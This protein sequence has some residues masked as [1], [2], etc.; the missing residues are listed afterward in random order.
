L[1]LCSSEILSIPSNDPFFRALPFAASAEAPCVPRWWEGKLARM[2]APEMTQRTVRAFCLL[3]GGLD[4]RLAVCVLRD[5]GIEV[6]GLAFESPFFSPE[7]PR[8]AAAQLEI[9]LR[10]VDFTADIVALLKNPPHGFGSCL[11]PCIDC[12]ARMLRRAGEIMVRDG[13][14]FLAT[15]EV[16]NERPMSQNKRSLGIVA[17]DSGYAD[18]I[19]RPLSA[20]LLEPTLPEREGWVDRE[21]LLDLE[22]RGRRRQITLA[23][24]Y[25]L[26]QYPN[27]AGGCRLTEPTFCTRLKDLKDHEGLDDVRAIRLLRCGRHFRLGPGLKL[28]MGRDE[29]D[30]QFLEST[31]DPSDWLIRAETI[32]G[33]TALLPAAAT[34]EQIGQA[35]AICVRYSDAPG[36]ESVAVRVWSGQ[37][38]RRLQVAAMPREE[39]DRVRLG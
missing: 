20:R 19:L 25:G 9:P 10:L 31:A 28:I 30:N 38:E 35:A 13:F 18:L 17:K 8:E 1:A 3:S 34:E 15:G 27:P 16:L 32:P 2:S 39:A 24:H 6:H 29:A 33:P 14:D 4:S 21:R 22:G 11:N 7:P 36:G 23:A 26:H 12:H 37:Q 5:Q